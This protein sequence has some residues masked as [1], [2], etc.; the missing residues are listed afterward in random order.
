[1]SLVSWAI[2]LWPGARSLWR[3]GAWS[4]LAWALGFALTLNLALVASF[5]WT[6][7]VSP[8]A[9]GAS[10]TLVVGTWVAGMAMGGTPARARVQPRA[11]GSDDLFQAALG[12]YLQRRWSEAETRLRQCLSR[13][14]DDF[15]ARLLLMALLRR[16]ERWT[17]ARQELA[18][19]ESHEA[20]GRW[21]WELARERAVFA[22]QPAAGGRAAANWL[23]APVARRSARAA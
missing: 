6:E 10:W 19:L 21:H 15:E 16:T 18:R 9:C 23:A 14:P 8:A 2:G 5:V 4:G 22:A 7:L 13:R 3:Q 20:A 12:E 17:E 1:M 11:E